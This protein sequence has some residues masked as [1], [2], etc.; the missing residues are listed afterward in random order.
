MCFVLACAFFETRVDFCEVICYTDFAKPTEYFS[1]GYFYLCGISIPF[2][3]HVHNEFVK[4]QIPTGRGI[5][6]IW[7]LLFS[8]FGD[9]RSLRF[10]AVASV[11]ALFY[12]GDKLR[13]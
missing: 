5:I 7:F 2:L 8:W 12:W 10:C 9:Y 1:K 3:C 13:I 4:M 6:D 11:A